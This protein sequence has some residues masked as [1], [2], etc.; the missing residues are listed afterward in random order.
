M[1]DLPERLHEAARAHRPDRE[2]MLAR[3]EHA[4]AE[5]EV[6]QGARAPGH[7]RPG[8]APWVRVTAVT[9][10]VAGAIGLGGLAV[11]AVGTAGDDPG[12]P[13]VVT[14]A[15][16]P[17]G[18][19]PPST[20]PSAPAS[21]A[22]PSGASGA[23][24]HPVAPRHGRPSPGG[25]H[26][27]GHPPASGKPATTA[28]ANPSGSSA[29]AGAGRDTPATTAPVQPGYLS[30]TASLGDGSSATWTESRVV[31]TTT[32][33]VTAL[34]V[35]LR[36]A[37]GAKVASTGAWTDAPDLTASSVAVDGDDLVYRWTLDDGRTL[38]AG[39]YTFAGQF[40][41]PDG[42]H[43]TAGDRFT[44]STQGSAGPATAGGGF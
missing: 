12:S 38:P 37:G 3:V 13:A 34:T 19:R 29:D 21:T 44:V 27:A 33:P 28:P 4:M 25:K 42:Q 7:D 36:V 23:A 9:A 24:G 20:P 16:S 6:S 11:G 43:G 5:P 30:C 41:H 15:G 35:E 10:A 32:A 14:S 2:R 1:A 40:S 31:L 17:A 8:S 22:G 26:S 18:T 39:S